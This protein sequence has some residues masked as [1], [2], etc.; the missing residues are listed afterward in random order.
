MMELVMNFSLSILQPCTAFPHLFPCLYFLSFNNQILRESPTRAQC[1][2][3]LSVGI[4]T[5]ISSAASLTTR[6]IEWRLYA[7]PGDVYLPKFMPYNS[8]AASSDHLFAMGLHTVL[9]EF[10]GMNYL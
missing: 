8:K 9:K 4:S 10:T 5:F 3:Q 7:E 6:A 2:N 1:H